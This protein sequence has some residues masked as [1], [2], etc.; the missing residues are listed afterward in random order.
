MGSGLPVASG[1][2]VRPLA[3][4]PDAVGAAAV[5]PMPGSPP[6]DP[7]LPRALAADGL[8]LAALAGDPVLVLALGD[9]K[10]SPGLPPLPQATMDATST[11]A[12]A[13]ANTRRR[14]SRSAAPSI[15]RRM[16]PIDLYHLQIS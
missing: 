8:L 5:G 6:V 10:L 9:G 16:K 4:G 14:Q 11:T 1:G 15:L 2:G 3:P 12:P 7:A 13:V